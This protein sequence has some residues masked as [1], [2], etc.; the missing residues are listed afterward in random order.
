[1]NFTTV[2]PTLAVAMFCITLFFA[3]APNGVVKWLLSGLDAIV[4]LIKLMWFLNYIRSSAYDFHAPNYGLLLLI[5]FFGALILAYPLIRLRAGKLILRLRRSGRLDII[6]L[7]F[8]PIFFCGAIYALRPTL[9]RESDHSP[10]FDAQYF[11]SHG[12]L[13][14]FMLV[15]GLYFLI[16]GLQ[17][18]ELRQ[19][20]IIQNNALWSWQ[21][22]ESHEWQEISNNASDID[23]ILKLRRKSIFGKQM[24][25]TMPLANGQTIEE[26]LAQVQP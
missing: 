9:Y 25:L 24:K 16:T 4:W 5:V 1:M 21:S 19:R 26:L 11:N 18:I 20:G 7:I 2:F 15:M 3:S 8:V 22:F 23:L 12:V 14:L 10:I 6:G 13:F 17:R